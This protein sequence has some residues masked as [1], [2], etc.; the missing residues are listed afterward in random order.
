MNEFTCTIK[1][2]VG[3]E[4]AKKAW[5]WYQSVGDTQNFSGLN[6]PSTYKKQATFATA[7][8]RG[9]PSVTWTLINCWPSAIEFGDLD[10][11]ASDLIHINMT[12]C[13]DKV[14]QG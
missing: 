1:D 8:G 6:P 2:Y 5:A 12:I 7:D 4:T 10:Y 14:I 3:Y 13:A 9:Y 11:S